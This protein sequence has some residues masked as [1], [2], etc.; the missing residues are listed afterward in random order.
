[1]NASHA[2]LDGRTASLAS[3][4]MLAFAGNSLLCRAALAGTAMDAAG[5]TVVRLASGAL[6]LWVL[7]RMRH[8][9]STGG[10]GGNWPSAIALFAYAAAFSF[11]YV[12]LSAATGALLLFGAVQA[13]MIGAGMARGER[14]RAI[15]LA[16]FALALVGLAALLLPGAT[17]PPLDGALTMVGAGIAWGAYSL[18]GG[19]A[20]DPLGETAGNFLRT[21]PFA[22]LLALAASGSLSLDPSGIALAA[23]SGALASGLG[24]AVWYA[25]LPRLSALRASILQL[26]VPVL[27]ALGGVA[28]LAEVLSLRLVACSAA[29]L[30][31][32]LLV[33]LSGSRMRAAQAP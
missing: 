18:R 3:L 30:G 19:R 14:F 22:A 2:S 10:G 8:S 15:Q 24:Y 32:V 23:A 4:A 20:L 27:T 21:L 25:V 13:T 31:G 6:V 1:M 12:Q 29:V 5:F 26:S 11:A 28:L 9:A 16:G 17:A 7:L 33:V